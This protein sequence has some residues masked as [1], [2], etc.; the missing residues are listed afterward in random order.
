MPRVPTSTVLP[1]HLRLQKQRTSFSH[2]R[3]SAE[4]FAKRQRPSLFWKGTRNRG[5]S[6]RRSKSEEL[7][8]FVRCRFFHRDLVDALRE[9][10]AH[11]F[12]VNM[13]DRNDKVRRQP[14]HCVDEEYRRV[15]I[16]FFHPEGYYFFVAVHGIAHAYA[17]V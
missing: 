8:D 4:I 7:E 10:R 16:V 17:A 11:L 14:F 3:R 13:F 5:K 12:R 1:R 15:H 6:H 2:A 9:E